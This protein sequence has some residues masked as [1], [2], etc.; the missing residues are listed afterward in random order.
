MKSYKLW[1][2]DVS[3]DVEEF[4]S[5]LHLRLLKVAFRLLFRRMHLF[6]PTQRVC[7]ISKRIRSTNS[8]DDH[9]V[10]AQTIQSVVTEKGLSPFITVS[11]CLL[12]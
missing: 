4:S 7:I 3:E 6:F 10:M 1:I 11:L 8:L 12:I 2:N 9:E 5:S